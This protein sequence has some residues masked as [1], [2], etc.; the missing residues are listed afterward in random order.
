MTDVN[1]PISEI[2]LTFDY[3]WRVLAGDATHIAPKPEHRFDAKRKWRFDRAWIE[4]RV[5]VELDGGVYSNGRHTRGKGFENDA[6]KLNAA[7]SDGWR[8][9]RFTRRMLESD[10]EGCINM[11]LKAVRNGK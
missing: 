3:Y 8:V 9:F 5:A 4:Q 7:V 6:E 10:P 11:V 2:E 1:R